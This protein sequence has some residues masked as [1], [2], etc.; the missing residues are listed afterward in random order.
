MQKFKP[1]NFKRS[2]YLAVGVFAVV[3]A[4]IKGVYGPGET[5]TIELNRPGEQVQQ[6]DKEGFKLIH[7]TVTRVPD[8]DT[9]YIKTSN[10]REERVRLL[11]IDAPEGKMPYGN[12]S[13]DNLYRMLIMNGFK[14]EVAYREKDQYGRLVGKLMTDGND[15][16]YAQVRDGYAWVYTPYVKD[17]MSSDRMAYRDAESA[18]RREK[19]GLWQD[20]NPER[21][22]EWRRA[23]P[24]AN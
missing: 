20:P 11:G 15:L 12:K 7:A 2:V 10:G 3:V 14:A 9:V 1:D 19:L 13:R 8:G 23:H 16:N 6:V 24:R 22:W 18:A 21:P 4:L 5:Q 17:M